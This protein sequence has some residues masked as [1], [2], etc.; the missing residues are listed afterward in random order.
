M[1]RRVELEMICHG[2]KDGEVVIEVSHEGPPGSAE[3]IF[4]KDNV[5]LLLSTTLNAIRVGP[6]SEDERMAAA[7]SCASMLGH[8]LRVVR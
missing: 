6:Y 5:L 8:R 3:V 2:Q 7:M 1:S 4:T